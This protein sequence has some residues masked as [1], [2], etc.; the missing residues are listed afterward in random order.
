MHRRRDSGGWA[1]PG[2]VM[3]V[4]ETTA[5]VVAREVTEETGITVKPAEPATVRTCR[6]SWWLSGLPSRAHRRP[7]WVSS[8][9]WSR[10]SP[11]RRR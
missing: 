4:D 5:A 6:R 10:R 3:D 2:G 11:W 1:L 9:R 8:S 7:P